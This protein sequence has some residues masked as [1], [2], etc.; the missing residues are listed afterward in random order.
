MIRFAVPADSPAIIQLTAATGVFK[1]MEIEVLQD[2]LDEYYFKEIG[3]GHVANVVVANDGT[4]LAYAYYAPTEMTDRTWHL[5]WIAV[6]KGHQGRGLGTELLWYI[7]NDIRLRGGRLLVIE[8]SATEPY[9]PTRKFYA[10]HGYT[11]VAVVPDF[12]AEGDG[13]VI[14]TKKLSS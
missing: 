9:A 3:N 11:N 2:V 12:Y 14:F 4:L 5:Y 10:K 13:M 1:P 8:T 7:E 6:A